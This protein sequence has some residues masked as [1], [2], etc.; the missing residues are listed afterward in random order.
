VGIGVLV[1]AG[2]LV[3]TDVAVAPNAPPLQAKTINATSTVTTIFFNLEFLFIN[4]S[5]YQYEI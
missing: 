4:S 5:N 3:G 2:V 1:A